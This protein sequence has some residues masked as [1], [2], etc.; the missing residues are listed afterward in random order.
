MAT[1]DPA[2]LGAANVVIVVIDTPAD[3]LNPTTET[4]YYLGSFFSSLLAPDTPGFDPN[5]RWLA[6]LGDN[7][8]LLMNS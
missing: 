6:V 1:S 5:S 3:G 2:C 4:N 7:G 8:L